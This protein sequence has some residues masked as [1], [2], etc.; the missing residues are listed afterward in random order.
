VQVV[1]LN[2]PV[3]LVVKVT[4]PVGVPELDVTIAVQLE[5]VLSRISASEQLTDVV[6]ATT[7]TPTGRLKVP[8]LPLWTLSPP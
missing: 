3:E 4:E 5:G 6:V 8:L 2:V 1:A 7:V